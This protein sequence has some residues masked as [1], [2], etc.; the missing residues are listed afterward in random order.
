MVELTLLVCFFLLNVNETYISITNFP[1]MFFLGQSF[2]QDQPFPLQLKKQQNP[3]KSNKRSALTS[4]SSSSSS[5]SVLPLKLSSEA[6]GRT[7]PPATQSVSS[8][9][10]FSHGLLGLSQPNGVIQSTQDVPLALTTKTRSDVPVNLSTGGR[11]SSA[12][13]SPTPNRSR[14]PR[15]SK[16]PK[17]L[18]AWKGLSQ[19]HL[20]QS[21]VDLFQHSGA[22]QELPSSKDSDDS[23]E[24][25]DDEDDDVEDEEDDDEED[26]DDSLSGEI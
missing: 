9:L 21:L 12:S 1:S 8:S 17:A 7:K 5:S 22:E 24:D 16:T 23:A 11:K 20:V 25:E 15:K 2:L 13:A 4:S 6:S 14:D 10:P 3:F 19:N 18:E 26:S